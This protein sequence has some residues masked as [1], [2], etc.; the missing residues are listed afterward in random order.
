MGDDR[1]SIIG[2]DT[3]VGR[4]EVVCA[5]DAA[6]AGVVKA[7]DT[8]VK[9]VFAILGESSARADRRLDSTGMLPDR[10]RVREIWRV[11]LGR[12]PV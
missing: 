2:A 7:A 5:V 11:N 10:R 1:A 3:G 12:V 8:G 6:E 4:V 9:G